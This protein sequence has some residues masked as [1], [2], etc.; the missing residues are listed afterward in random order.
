MVSSST[1]RLPLAH[2]DQN[3][4]RHLFNAVT[5]KYD[6]MN[7]LFSLGLD[8]YWRRRMVS[9]SLTGLE[10]SILDLGVGTGKS[11]QTFLNAHHFA[12]AVGCDFSENMLM[13]AK[14]RLKDRA[15]LMVCDFHD[16][17]FP[18]QTFDI[19]TGSFILRSVQNMEHFLSEAKRIL[20][21]TGKVLYLELTR[22]ENPFAW[23]LF[24]PYLQFYIP[25]VG[26]IFSRHDEAYQFLSESV[27]SFMTPEELKEKFL[28]AQF[29]TVSIRPLTFGA[30]TL[31]EGKL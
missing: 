16:L 4:I 6:F 12:R 24:K 29:K 13:E 30:A 28:T 22:P 11:L 14:K 17:P 3:K 2:P 9:L 23:A 21:P 7:S 18:S 8:G 1:E 19:V 31:I 25:L 15:E 20:K 10:R 5:S 27:R 26:K